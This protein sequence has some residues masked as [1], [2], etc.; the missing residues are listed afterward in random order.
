MKIFVAGNPLL[1]EDSLPVKL[2]PMMRE[3]FPEIVFEE[4]DPAGSLEDLGRDPVIIDT[5][6]GIDDF[7][8]ITDLEQIADQKMYSLHDFDLGINLKL[9]KKMGMLNSVRII[10]IPTYF[11]EEEVMEHLRKRIPELGGRA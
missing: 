2:L 10:G 4:F 3:E 11:E 5:V 8:E 7:I 6:A 9:M 1:K